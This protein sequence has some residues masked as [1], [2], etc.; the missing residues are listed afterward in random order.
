MGRGPQCC[1]RVA[2]KMVEQGLTEVKRMDVSK[3]HMKKASLGR[4]EGLSLCTGPYSA[5]L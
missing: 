5:T 4:R 3:E 2:S 1:K